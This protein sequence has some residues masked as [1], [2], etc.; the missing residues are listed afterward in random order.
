[1]GDT[2]IRNSDGSDCGTSECT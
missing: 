1:M 2:T